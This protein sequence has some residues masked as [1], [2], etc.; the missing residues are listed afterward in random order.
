MTAKMSIILRNQSGAALV[1]ALIMI[2][3]ITLIALASSYT[4]LFEIKIAGNKRGLTDAFYAAE[5]GINVITSNPTVSFSPAYYP[6]PMPP[7]TTSTNSNPF[8]N[9]P[10]PFNNLANQN[11]AIFVTGSITNISNQSGPP[12]GGGY[13]AVNVS[14][15][16]FQIQCTGTDS[17]VGGVIGVSGAQTTVQ[18]DVIE[19]IPIA[20]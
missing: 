19:V 15:A 3:V 17:A 18:E 12:R 2:I 7:T 13:S 5:T 6:T 8:N 20:Q 16:Y 4:S 10:S 9:L 1:I 11:P 14:Y